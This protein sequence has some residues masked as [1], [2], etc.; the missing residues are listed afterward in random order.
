[1]EMAKDYTT[2]EQAMLHLPGKSA[3]VAMNMAV[4]GFK[5]AGKA[6]PH[7]VVVCKHLATVL[8]GGDTDMSEALTEQQLL[9]LEF[10]SF[11]ELV[12]HKDSLARI[13]HIL[14]T[15]KPLRN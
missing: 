9:D 15:G 8:S 3:K 12:K 10:E 6:T 1:M 5:A 4:D 13:E 2:P 14:D 7:D 11:M